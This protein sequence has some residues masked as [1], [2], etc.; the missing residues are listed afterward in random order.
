MSTI[1][2]KEFIVFRSA[3]QFSSDRS[4]P[5]SPTRSAEQGRSLP[6]ADRRHRSAALQSQKPRPDDPP[7]EERHSGFDG[8][9][10][11]DP[12]SGSNL[13]EGNGSPGSECDAGGRGNL[14]LR[15]RGRFRVSDSGDAHARSIG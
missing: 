4:Q 13:P 8:R 2:M 12:A 15:D 3:V 6:R 10:N 11:D 5:R 14:F 1:E 7:L 9:R